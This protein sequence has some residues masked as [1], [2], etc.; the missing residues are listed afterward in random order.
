MKTVINL[1]EENIYNF[2]QNLGHGINLGTCRD[3]VLGRRLDRYLELINGVFGAGAVEKS[4]Y[5]KVE[6]DSNGAYNEIE[7]EGVFQ[8]ICR[9][10]NNELANL[11]KSDFDL[12]SLAYEAL[13]G[14]KVT[15][16]NL[17]SEMIVKYASKIAKS[18]GIRFESKRGVYKFNGLISSVSL[19]KQIQ[20]AYLRGDRSIS[21]SLLEANPPTIRC[22]VSN[23]SSAY[24]KKFRC[25]SSSGKITVH[26]KELSLAEKCYNELEK[27]YNE[28]GPEIS[29]NAF[30][31]MMNR[32]EIGKDWE[33]AMKDNT[34]DR[35]EL[36][37]AEFYDSEED[38][39]RDYEEENEIHNIRNIEGL[40]QYYIAE[41]ENGSETENPGSKIIDDDDF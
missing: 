22:Y 29:K 30:A 23:M 12:E 9:L 36:P 31:E 1:A 7:E 14:K 3:V 26:F 32:L 4:N 6:F 20:D 27:L 13:S 11:T 21:F 5:T 38:Q 40:P 19:S 37:K 17:N 34:L 41:L 24:N 25:E 15:E 8:I 10:K 28:Y 18:V 35:E 2:L 33:E 39:E 16:L